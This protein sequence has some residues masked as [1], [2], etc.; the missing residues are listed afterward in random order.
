ML[1]AR[2][3]TWRRHKTV[4]RF[5]RPFEGFWPTLLGIIFSQH[6]DPVY[7]VNATPADYSAGFRFLCERARRPAIPSADAI[8]PS[9]GIMASA[10]IIFDLLHIF[11]P[12]L[13][14]IYPCSVANFFEQVW[15]YY[16]IL[17]YR[18]YFISYAH[19]LKYSFILIFSEIFFV[20]VDFL[21]VYARDAL[22]RFF[23]LQIMRA[24]KVK[25]S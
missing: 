11:T 4:Y 10:T 22:Y 24:L 12:S 25:G 17:F 9:S 16:F 2:L 6:R 1:S 18:I 8:R 3:A 15:C 14:S 7:S 5:H 21:L 13:L 23:C 19:F 20:S